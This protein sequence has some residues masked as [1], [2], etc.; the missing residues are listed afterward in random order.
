MLT[1]LDKD[2]I[3]AI[4]TPLGSGAIGIIRLSGDDAWSIVNRIF[5]PAGA[6]KEKKNLPPS[7]QFLYGYIKD[8]QTGNMIDEVLVVLMKAPKS[9]TR[10]D[11]VE[12]QSHSGPAILRKILS[13]ILERGAR[14]AEA[15]EFTKRA[16]LNGRI[17]LS[18]AESVAELIRARTDTAVHSAAVLISG[19][20]KENVNRWINFIKDS[21][22]ELEAG[23][24]F[25]DETNAHIDPEILKIKILKSIIDPVKT[26]IHQYD[27]GHVLRDGIRLDIV[28]RPNVGKSSL[29]NRLLKK[30]K[31]I[32]SAVPGTTRDLVE[33]FFSIRGIPINIT[34]TAGLH[35]SEDPIEALGMEKTRENIAQS[36]LILCVIDA[37]EPFVQEDKKILEALGD[38][39]TLLVINK[40]DLIDKQRKGIVPEKYRH[41]QS[42]SISALTGEGIDDLKDTISNFCLGGI[43][44]ETGKTLIPSLRQKKLLEAALIHLENVVKDIE[45]NYSEDMIAEELDQALSLLQNITGE[46]HNEQIMDQVFER[47]CI[48]K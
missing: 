31:A 24:E 36:N 32:V 25:G 26:Y 44:L 12:I 34:D 22:V 27:S 14:L 11:V 19:E 20:M 33:D 48:G 42:V 47:F 37:M 21:L 13:M 30:N 9:Y 23:I 2:T 18:Q 7:H 5:F 3:T 39:S 46:G 6:S 16:F 35:Q 45:N 4:A 40:I 43:H 41:L 38:K 28:G 10:E 29:L 8:P 1:H 15:G 17:D